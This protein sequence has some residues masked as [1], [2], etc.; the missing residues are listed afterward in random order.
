[1]NSEFVDNILFRINNCIE[2]NTFDDVETEKVEVKDLSSG[3]DWTSLR[4]TICAFLNT[5]G[6]VIICGIRERNNAYTFSGFDRRNE[7]KLRELID[8]P[9]RDDKSFKDDKNQDV[10]F[11]ADYISF[12]YLSF[13]DGEVA[14]IKVKELDVDKKYIKYNNKYYKRILTGDKEIS[15]TE[16]R[17]HSEYKKE[18]EYAKEISVL[19]GATIEDFSLDKIN[20]YILLL[21]RDVKVETI[22]SS[23]G[24]AKEFLIKQHFIKNDAVTVLGMLVCGN[25]PFHFLENRSEVVCHYDTSTNIS[26]DKKIFR[27]DVIS[28]IDDTNR[29]VWGHIKIARTVKDGGSAEPEYPEV[30]IREVINNAIAHRDY[31]INNFITVTIEPNKYLEIKNPGSFKEQMIVLHPKHEIP[32]MRIVPGIHESKNPKLASVLRIFDK[33]ESQGRGMASLINFAIENAVDLPY[34]EIKD[35][36]INLKIPSGKLVD[37][38]IET[39][40]NGYKKYITQRLKKELSTEH[41]QVLAYLYKSEKLNRKRLF[42]ILLSEANN[43]Y[44]VIEDLK[45]SNLIYEHPLSTEYT[46][47]YIVDRVLA[48]TG[49]EKEIAAIVG[50]GYQS[51]S[52]EAKKILDILFR[53]TKYNNEALKPVDITPEVYNSTYT[54]KTIDPKKYESLGRK[55]R[56]LCSELCNNEQILLQNEK[57]EYSFNLQYSSKN[58]AG[59]FN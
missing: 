14:V 7:E 54:G 39:W 12:E 33:I 3:S 15:Q 31:T 4:E 35:N 22:K 23:M 11:L 36:T 42:T 25:D 10:T 1:M 20:N 8:R 37:T 26:K 40:L 47:V 53:F 41:K 49:F 2:R 13:G 24:I 56:K 29:Y 52:A 16:L 5:N 48:Q 57:K 50:D 6:G 28:L 9:T 58:N 46:P 38:E 59:I 30:M 34:Y 19:E 32:I 45:K 27:N 51:F 43:H 17:Q 55:V 44:D 18:L 21:N